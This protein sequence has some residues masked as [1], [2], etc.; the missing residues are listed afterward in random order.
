MEDKPGYGLERSGNNFMFSG[1]SYRPADQL[2]KNP[3]GPTRNQLYH[4][5]E[6]YQNVKLNRKDIDPVTQ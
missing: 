1:G 4:I 3:T 5:Y 2:N 6:L